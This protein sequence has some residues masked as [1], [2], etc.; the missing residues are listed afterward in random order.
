M[1]EASAVESM[2]K[3]TEHPFTTCQTDSA[4]TRQRQ[5]RY[6]AH[7]VL[8]AGPV[9][10]VLARAVVGCWVVAGR[11]VEAGAVD[12]AR[13]VAAM[14]VTAAAVEGCTAVVPPTVD[15]RTVAPGADVAPATGIQLHV[16][17]PSDPTTQSEIVPGWHLHARRG[18]QV[19]RAGAGVVTNT[20]EQTGQP[21]VCSMD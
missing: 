16:W 11:A 19:T 8:S 12:G 18:A 6:G 15:C 21:V 17:H 9:A 20:Q 10:G 5:A 3:H 14:V 1:V 13:V 7:V 2:Q 4:P